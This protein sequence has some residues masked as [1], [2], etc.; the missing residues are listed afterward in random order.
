MSPNQQLN[1]LIIK[2]FKRFISHFP[3]AVNKNRTE[4]P[5]ILLVNGILVTVVGKAPLMIAWRRPCGAISIAIASLGICFSTSSNKTLLNKLFVWYSGE[6]YFARSESQFVSGT[7]LLIHL[8][9]LI[10]GSLMT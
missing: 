10:F 6:E 2:A 9:D 7:E 3:I 4:S 8:D 5:Y 1:R